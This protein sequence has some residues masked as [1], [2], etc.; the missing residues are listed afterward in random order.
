MELQ[1]GCS[2]RHLQ[3]RRQ[4]KALLRLLLCNVQAAAVPPMVHSVDQK[5]SAVIS[6]LSGLTNDAVRATQARLFPRETAM[7]DAAIRNAVRLHHQR[8]DAAFRERRVYAGTLGVTE[9][10]LCLGWLRDRCKLH[11]AAGEDNLVQRLRAATGKTYAESTINDAIRAASWSDKKAEQVNPLRD[12][13]ASAQVRIDVSAYPLLCVSSLD[14]SHMD[15]R[16]WVRR[17]GRAPI[18]QAAQNRTRAMPGA[19][20][21]SLY[22]LMNINGMVT[23]ACEVIDGAIDTVRF[24]QWVCEYLVPVLRRFDPLN[25]KPNSVLL[26]DNVSFHREPEF[27]ALLDAMGVKYIFL[28]PYDP[29]C[30]PIERAFNQV[31]ESC[32]CAC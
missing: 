7:D 8:G 16:T 15:A 28:T 5:R 26:L 29:R 13:V 25:P 18:G 23:D 6:K 1:A 17:R 27:L 3:C 21:K 2:I 31:G 30:Q 22:A 10:A 24:M 9:T 19:G 11:T 4:V 12:P 20:L 14:A 32:R